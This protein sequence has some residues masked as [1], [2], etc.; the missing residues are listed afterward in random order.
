MRGTEGTGRDSPAA[1][2]QGPSAPW[3]G[4]PAWAV[5]SHWHRWACHGP[6]PSTASSQHG[7]HRA[8]PWGQPSG[9]SGP[10]SCSP[11]LAFA[12]S[13]AVCALCGRADVDPNVCGHTFFASGIHVHEFCFVSSPMASSQI[14]TGAAPFPS[15][16]MRSSS[17]LSC[18]CLPTPFPKHDQHGWD[19]KASPLLSS[20]AQSGRQ[21]RR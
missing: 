4:G 7:R 1:A 13:S 16:L 10:A 18:R 9:T 8:G 20:D 15:V 12:L 5:S 6:F 19:L 11:L 14:P 17:F 3:Q 21:T 2:S